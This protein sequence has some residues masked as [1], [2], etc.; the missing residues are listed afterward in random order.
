MDKVV[1]DKTAC[2]GCGL[3]EKA[4]PHRL[5]QIENDKASALLDGC[6]EC[7][8]CRAVC[9]SG[10]IRMNGIRDRLEFENIAEHLESIRPG[11]SDCAELVQLMRSRRSCRNYSSQEVQLNLLEDL[12]KIGTTAPSGTNSQSWNFIILPKRSDVEVLGNLTADFYRKLNAQAANPFYRLI[13]RLAAGDKLG[14]YYRSH[15]ESVDKA[16]HEWD[17]DGVDRLFH[18]ATAAILITGKKD[19]S[20]P[21]EDAMLATQNILL[22]A[23]AL[24]LGTCLIGFVVEAMR[25]SPKSMRAMAI[26]ADEEIYSVI[27]LGYPAIKY[28]RVAGRRPVRPRVLHLGDIR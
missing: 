25:R 10:A 7:G 13:A 27:G 26:P 9:S 5:I 1:I 3:C 21:A 20:C 4:C 23:H 18:G 12:V 8:H 28:S 16:L 19:A 14:E 24:G 17:V 15:Y 2:N 11:K 6:M 22:A